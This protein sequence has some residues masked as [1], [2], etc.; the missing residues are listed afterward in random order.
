MTTTL[1]VNGQ[2]HRIEVDEKTPLLWV[3]RDRLGLKGTKY[4]CGAALCG[5]CSIHLDGEVVRSCVCPTS[6]AVGKEIT[7]IEGLSDGR[8]LHPV[9]RAWV[10]GQVPQCGYCQAGVIMTAASLLK[11]CP[12]PTDEQIE[13]SMTNLCRCGTYERIRQ[14]IHRAAADQQR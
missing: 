14:A 6:R 7:T 4:G 1:R 8:Q 3:L 13:Q 12:R 11:H 10:E 2:E 5:A 9:Q